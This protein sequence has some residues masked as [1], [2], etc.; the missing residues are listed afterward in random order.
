MPL[1]YES[2]KTH[3]RHSP[4]GLTRRS[5]SRS[6]GPVG[7][8]SL[9]LSAYGS[10]S[11]PVPRASS[12]VGAAPAAGS[13][14]AAWAGRRFA[15][16][17]CQ[18]RGPV[19]PSF[20][21]WSRT[22]RQPA[23]SSSTSSVAPPA[24]EATRAPP[25]DAASRRVHLVTMRA[26]RVGAVTGAAAAAGGS[27]VDSTSRA[28]TGGGSTRAPANTSKAATTANDAAT[29]SARSEWVAPLGAWLRNVGGRGLAGACVR[30]AAGPA[31]TPSRR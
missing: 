22:R 4:N 18:H 24:I 13:R 27:A 21:C 3:G 14:D 30:L 9:A 5:L 6:V 11:A 19:H 17:A 7:A 16:D 2:A 23:R 10:R 25:A 28:S 1:R 26:D 8:T 20:P 15:D 31:T 29:F 12:V